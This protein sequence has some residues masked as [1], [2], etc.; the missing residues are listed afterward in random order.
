MEELLDVVDFFEPT[1]LI[2][3]LPRLDDATLLKV[4]N[5]VFFPKLP[6]EVQYKLQLHLMT[7]NIITIQQLDK[8]GCFDHQQFYMLAKSAE[9]T[10]AMEYALTQGYYVPT[11]H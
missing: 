6:H 2:D 10:D 4:H 1:V 9:R 8:D 5:I 11:T 3:L 7:R